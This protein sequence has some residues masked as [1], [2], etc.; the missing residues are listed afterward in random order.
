MANTTQPTQQSPQEF[1]AGVTPE[2]RREEGERLLALM[3]EVTGDEGVMW[4]PTMVGFGTY[5][6]RYASGREGDMFRVGFSPR[7]AQLSLYGINEDPAQKALLERLGP[8][9]TGASCVYV[10][11]LDAIDE[12][13]LRDLVDLG[14]QHGDIDQTA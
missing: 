14:Y 4:G 7:K 3:A 5:H 10:K 8:H 9:T 11:R 13:V 12:E 6:Y 2:R 1:L